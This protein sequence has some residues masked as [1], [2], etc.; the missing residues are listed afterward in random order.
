MSC[1]NDEVELSVLDEL[2]VDPVAAVVVE[3]DEESL[4]LSASTGGAWWPWP[5]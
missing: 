5:P 4:S 3:L 1:C 2:L